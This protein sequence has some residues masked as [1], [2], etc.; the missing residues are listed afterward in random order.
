MATITDTVVNGSYVQLPAG[1]TAQRPATPTTG[2]TRFNTTLN[3]MEFWNGTKWVTVGVLDG[4]TSS[5]AATSAAAIKSLTGTTTNGF[6]WILNNGT[7]TQV[8]CDMNNDGGGWMMI[9]RIHTDTS[10]WTYDDGVW[11]SSTDFN[12]GQPYDYGGHIKHPMYYNR[13]F[14]QVRIA[15]NTITNG[16]VESTWSNGTSFANFMTYGSSTSNSRATWNTWVNTALGGSYSWLVNCNQIGTS[17]AYNYQYV[18]LGATVNGENDCTSN[19]E[20]FGF[21]VKGI[22]PYGNVIAS[23]AYSPYNGVGAAARVGWIFI[24]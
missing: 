2:M 9:A 19:D 22:S 11:T 15:M 16:I 8:W 18:K 24:K 14:S 4:S 23:G 13:A 12:S 17:K 5:Q 20:G 21:G 3:G 10:Y 6:Y 7:P 1:T